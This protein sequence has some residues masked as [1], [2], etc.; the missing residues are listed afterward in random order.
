MRKFITDNKRNILI[1]CL[2]GTV[3]IA[4]YFVFLGAKDIFAFLSR[5]FSI[6]KPFIYAYVVAFLAFPFRRRFIELFLK[7]KNI[8]EKTA[9]VIS[10]VIS[11]L[12][13]ATIL[14][15]LVMIIVPQIVDSIISL[16]NNIPD[17]VN[18]INEYINSLVA[19]HPE[20]RD[21]VRSID[22]SSI[23]G[24][25]NQFQSIFSNLVP[26]IFDFSLALTNTLINA[27]IALIVAFYIII[28]KEE[29]DLQFK[30]ITYFILKRKDA[31][32][33]MTC[34]NVFSQKFNSFL[35][36][37]TI[38]SV[39]VGII[40]YIGMLIFKFEYPV[41]ISVIVCVT[42]MI[43]VF[44]PFIGGIPGFLI[45]LIV[46]PVQALWFALFIFV[47]QQFDGNI[48]GPHI[49]HNSIKISTIWV[50][51]AI[52]VG[53]RYWGAPGMVIGVPLFAALSEIFGSLMDKKM[54]KQQAKDIEVKEDL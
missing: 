37:K 9:L 49:L 8:K 22:I 12:I 33:V 11:F 38:D 44:G 3:L 19:N 10:S 16:S 35:I 52:V 41:L 54:T 17:A 27:V 29:L 53:G 42:N 18:R 48:L 32:F 23:L 47:L 1:G 50:I 24:L 2:I 46:N 4:V 6:I 36:G 31:D 45:I 25:L 39:L 14:I 15:T 43:P 51:F 40:C 30:R 26:R 21:Y 13:V 7:I 20:L 34:V 5:F 28:Q